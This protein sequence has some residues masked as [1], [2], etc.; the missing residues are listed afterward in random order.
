VLKLWSILLHWENSDW[1]LISRHA[2][3]VHYTLAA[4][5]H[6]GHRHPILRR[7]CS[8]A[9][10]LRVTPFLDAKFL[11]KWDGWGVSVR[12][13]SQLPDI[14]PTDFHFCGYIKDSVVMFLLCHNPWGNCKAESMMQQSVFSVQCGI[15]DKV[16]FRWTSGA[17]LLEATSSTS[18]QK[19]GYWTTVV[20][21]LISL[22]VTS[23]KVIIYWF[24]TLIC[25]HSVFGYHFTCYTSKIQTVEIY[26]H[27][28][29]RLQD[30]FLKV[31]PDARN[32]PYGDISERRQLR[33][34]LKCHSFKWYVDN[35]Y[36][37]LTLPTD[38]DQRLKKKW[39]ALKPQKY[40]PWHSRQRN[41]VSHFQVSQWK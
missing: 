20:Q 12:W 33:E 39:D 2:G 34:R 5:G 22:Y 8:D 10:A 18:E 15:W 4:A 41:Y 13:P 36:P 32:M 38:N 21:Q 31:R 30:Y 35:V 28:Y 17:W 24:C 40:Q 26:W 3:T 14:T 16:A 27:I 23:K 9:L 19:F 11:N 25:S 6:W 37:E 7:Q 1:N 29:Y